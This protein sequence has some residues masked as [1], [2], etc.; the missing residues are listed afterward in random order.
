[1]RP[2]LARHDHAGEHTFSVVA[3]LFTVGDDCHAVDF[4]ATPI[5]LE[6]QDFVDFA[7]VDDSEIVNPDIA[8]FVADPDMAGAGVFNLGA[9][10]IRIV[11]GAASCGCCAKSCGLNC[12][13]AR[14]RPPRW[15]RRRN[16]C[17]P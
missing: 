6:L 17:G 8:L 10:E 13:N 11:W 2:Q 15:P 9:A 14:M 7:A 5:V 3:P 12:W 4:D 1:M 16:C